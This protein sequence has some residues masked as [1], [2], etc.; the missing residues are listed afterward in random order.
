MNIIDAIIFGIV[1][2]VTEYLPVSSTGHLLL[3]QKLLGLEFTGSVGDA[4]KA[5][6]VWIQGGA[7]LAVIWLYRT[8]F[9]SLVRGIIGGDKEGRRLL[10]NL[11]VAFAPAAIIALLFERAIKQHLFGL[12]PVVLAWFAGGVAILVIAK[13]QEQKQLRNEN[14]LENLTFRHA[15]IIGLLQCVAMWPGVSRSLITIVGGLVVGLRTQAAVEFSFLLG[16][17]TLS[18]AAMYEVVAHG[19]L[20]LLTFDLGNIATGFII[21]FVSAVLAVRWLVSYLTTHGFRLFGY[22][23]IGIAIAVIVLVETGK[24]SW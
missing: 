21:S 2:G 12:F 11:L 6:I 1:E 15:V 7:I 24:I 20:L 18:A 16:V 10:L 13:F 23:R 4:G 14:E 22:Y 19:E 17:V 5:F 9:Q 3:T 8:R